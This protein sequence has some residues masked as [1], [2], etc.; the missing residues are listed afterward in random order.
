MT[1]LD[2]LL[3]YDFSPLT[4]LSYMLVLG[5]YGVGLLRMP[6]EDRPGGL[7]IFAFVLGV[8]ICYGVMQTRFDYYAQYLS[9]IHI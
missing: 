2:Y 1:L 4:V 7:R 3:P 5:F 6:D 9:L 8:M